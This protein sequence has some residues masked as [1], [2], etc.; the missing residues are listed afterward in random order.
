MLYFSDGLG[1]Q[2]YPKLHYIE[3]FTCT[4][5]C[6]HKILSHKYFAFCEHNLDN[7]KQDGCRNVDTNPSIFFTNSINFHDLG[8]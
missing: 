8:F 1:K 2:L 7:G 6:W 4:M 5:F 3:Y